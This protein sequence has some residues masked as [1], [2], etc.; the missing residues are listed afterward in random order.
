MTAPTRLASKSQVTITTA[1]VTDEHGQVTT[2][3]TSYT[4]NCTYKIG[5]SRQFLDQAGNKFTPRTV[6]WYELPSQGRPSVGDTLQVNGGRKEQ[7]K[8]SDLQ[9]G[10]VAG[11]IPDVMLVT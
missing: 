7:I 1:P 11:E 6:V 2:P 5:S 10:S 8:V 4:V 3:G 9:D